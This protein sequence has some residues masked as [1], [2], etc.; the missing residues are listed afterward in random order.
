MCGILLHISK[1][2]KSTNKSLDELKK[3]GPDNQSVN[4]IK[5]KNNFITI[6][7]SRLGIIDVNSTSSNQPIVS[8]GKMLTFNGEIYNY[9]ELGNLYFPNKSF[10]SDTVLLFEFL[11][12]YPE[13]ILELKGMF[14]FSFVDLNKGMAIVVSDPFGK[15]PIYY[16]SVN[17][18]FTVSSTIKTIDYLTTI[19]KNNISK[20]ALNYYLKYNYTPVDQSIYEDVK[21]LPGG[22]ILRLNLNT[23]EFSIEKYFDPLKVSNSSPTKSIGNNVIIYDKLK[24]SVS[25]RLVA[26]VPIGIQLSSGIDSTLVASV[27]S[28]EFKI[29]PE[30]FT[31]TF[32]DPSHSEEKGAVAIAKNLGIKH[33]LIRMTPKD[34]DSCLLNYYQIYDEPFADPSAIPTIHL[35]KFVNKKNIRV[36]L[37]GDGGDE[38]WQG[39]NRY[40]TWPRIRNIFKYKRLIKPVLHV[41]KLKLFQSIILKLPAFK[42]LDL[43][44]FDIRLNQIIKVCNQKNLYSV[45]ESFLAQSD[46]QSILN[47]EHLQLIS[48]CSDKKVNVNSMSIN[49]INNYMQG[50]ILVKNDRASMF[51]SIE[52]RSP[53]LDIDFA[54]EALMTDHK[55]KADKEEG[56]KPL[57]IFLNH[58]LPEYS[59]MFKK[60]FG[61]PITEWVTEE[62]LYK[63]IKD[64]ISNLKKYSIINEK[65]IDYK[66]T[67]FELYPMANIY[68]IWNLFLLIKFFEENNINQFELK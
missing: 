49:D 67:Q 46:N 13:K 4:I 52:T 40:V 5:D 64:K 57:R 26:D 45:Y 47:N 10:N 29:K 15:K 8:E 33:N 19:N 60:G 30:A 25:R 9:K 68:S 21:K 54:E 2:K 32:D 41:F 51:Y 56:K 43:R 65:E 7:H 36:L 3:R 22:N 12:R 48:Q 31:I 63:F 55:I 24:K 39:Y 62:N 42:R 6:G 61:F 20:K 58:L 53:L 1:I 66:L 50:D 37:T 44:Q 27:A 18:E 16:S 11:N 35:N 28:K 14:A 59:E 38:F 34:L 23:L 17:D